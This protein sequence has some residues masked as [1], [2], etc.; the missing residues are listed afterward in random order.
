[1]GRRIDANGG[2][3]NGEA[4]A[5][6]ASPRARDDAVSRLDAATVSRSGTPP[7]PPLA[8]SQYEAML[9]A[10]YAAGVSPGSGF[11]PDDARA[12]D[13]EDGDD[14]GARRR[15]RGRASGTEEDAKTKTRDENTAEGRA[16]GLVRDLMGGYGD[17]AR[18]T[19]SSS[20][21]AG[22]EGRREASAAREAATSGL[23]T[24]MVGKPPRGVGNYDKPN[25]DD[26]EPVKAVPVSTSG[27]AKVGWVRI[28]TLG[29]VN[30]LSMEKT[31][32]ATLLRVPLRDLRVL[33][34]TTADSYSAAVLCRERAIV[35][36]LEQIKVLI[37]AEEVIMTDSQTST[38]THFLPE[39]QTRLLRRK[40]LRERDPSLST[41]PL[42][43]SAA[44][45]TNMM[46]GQAEKAK[47]ET[48]PEKELRQAQPTTDDFPFEFVALEVAL[49]M[50]C[51]TL[52]VEAN[53][54]ELD[55]K[56]A[57]EALRKRV[58]NVNLERVRRMK[59]RLVRV[60][61]RVSK[62]REEI[63]RYLD[64]D[65]DMRDMYL[66]RK[67]KQQSESL[68][69]E[70]SVT[71]PPPNGADGGQRGATAHYQLEHALSAS[72]GRSPLGVHGVHT[73]SGEAHNAYFDAY[74]EDK[75]LQELEDLLETYFTHV[76][77]THRS[78]NGLNEYIDDLEDL[79]EIELDSQRNQ[80][81]KLELILTTATLC[82]TCF[83][84][85]V[86]I[87]GMNIKNNVENEHGMFLLVVLLG[88]AATIGMFIILLRV[89][90]YYRLF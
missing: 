39:L 84:V 66:T 88:S 86:G 19:V 81:I 30:R 47:S 16:G 40:R 83:S 77:S 36:N 49:E 13:E 23:Q 57:L 32:I 76:D 65:S 7:L 25:G 62:V 12:S 69:R 80:L 45:L 38:V 58:D 61:G 52:E 44:D 82:L 56:P 22:A 72:S 10:Q 87:F 21:T 35:V 9:R 55:A 67:S 6:R 37:T 8:P 54:V 53:K 64:D 90:R 78:L 24:V 3:S 41:L 74:D 50:V 31:K 43:L 17:D 15:S 42:N 5:S 59:T 26:I 20:A 75:D 34:P 60:A 46:E 73:Q 2:A 33:E 51:N 18:G 14:E 63:Q 4:D 70:G 11:V 1:M 29:V 48:S 89:C 71:S 68:R 85:V 79:I 28:N 27:R